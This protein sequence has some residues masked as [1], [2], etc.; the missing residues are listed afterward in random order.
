MTY[1]IVVTPTA[2]K[3]LSDITDARIREK[4]VELIGALS[5]EPEK[6][7]KLLAGE[8]TG[9][10]SIRA[11]GQRYRIIFEIKREAAVVVI[12]AVG[13]RREGDRSDIYALAKKLLRLRLLDN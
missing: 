4:I 10:R 11:V 13:L 7:G 6:R 5:R 12:L 3:M 2:L 9:Y 1:R 8:L